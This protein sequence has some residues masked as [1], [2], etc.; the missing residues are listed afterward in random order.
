MKKFI[1]LCGMML[2]S[3]NMMAQIDPYDRNWGN[4]PVF[5]DNF[6]EQNRQFDNTFQEPLGKWISYAH[7]L[8]PSGVTKKKMMQIYQWDKSIIE[9][10]NSIIRLNSNYIRSTPI[11]CNEQL[12][13]LP[14]NTFGVNYQ[15]DPNNNELY[16]YS[17]MIESLPTNKFRYGYFE[18]KCKLPVHHGAFPAF[19][20]WDSQ[21]NEYYEEIDILEYSWD[22]T[23]E[24]GQNPS[25]PQIGSRRH[26]TSGIWYNPNSHQNY[27]SIGRV[28][29]EISENEDDL[30][31]WHIYGCE[32]L[33]DQVIFYRDGKAI[34]KVNGRANIPQHAMTLKA[35]YAIDRYAL[36]G[37]QLGNSPYWEGSDEMVIDYINVY[38]LNWDCSTEEIIARQLELDQFNYAVKKSITITSS[39]EPV[40]VQSTDKVT[41]RATDFFEITG[42]FQTD[43]GSEFTV[44]MQGCPE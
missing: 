7:C 22:F 23:G 42:S 13:T 37:Y 14:P 39:I 17:G 4:G 30:T 5:S 8:W 29:P 36:N 18:I 44:I 27:H 11:T 19:W 35:N 6:D 12:Y 24:S 16:Y 2:L 25:H 1:Y 3:M 33:P 38:Q 34:S 10:E 40:F 28:F 21:K 15:C 9:A 31:G 32:W 26:Y 43:S 20:L 41:F